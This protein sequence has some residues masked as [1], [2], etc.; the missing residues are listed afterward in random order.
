MYLKFRKRVVFLNRRYSIFAY[1]RIQMHV[2]ESKRSICHYLYI[3][4]YA[5]SLTLLVPGL[6]IEYM[7]IYLHILAS[8]HSNC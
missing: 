7:V 1:K 3:M 4:Y 6:T 8:Y 2:I 5:F